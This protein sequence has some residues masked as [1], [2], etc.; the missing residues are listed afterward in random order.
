MKI[1]VIGSNGFIGK[2][3]V[4]RLRKHS[5]DE[6]FS[7]DREDIFENGKVICKKM[8]FEN[9]EFI[10]ENFKEIDLVYYLASL[11]I[12]ATS[13]NDPVIEIEKNLSPFLKFMEGLKDCG[14]KKI[15]YVSSAGT[16]YG[17]T[18]GKVKEE[19][20]KKPFSPY[21]IIK[22]TIENFLEHYKIKS[23]IHYDVFRISNAYGPG[24]DTSKGLGLINTFLEKII[25]GEEIKIF[26]DGTST[27]NYIFIDDIS[28]LMLLSKI[29]L[30]DGGIYNLS[31]D[32]TVDINKVVKTIRDV[33][34]EKFIPKYF[35]SRQSD[36][37][38]IDLDNSKILNQFPEF[39]FTTLQEGIKKTYQSLKK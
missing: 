18:H 39:A 33:V 3:L 34:S 26:G 15:V 25:S 21:G 1:A 31:S 35:P 19:E 32:S 9:K 12:P 10:K 8:N 16:V 7:F 23:G 36:N 13:W 27:R 20:N 28:E 24:Q 6:I 29:N 11:T 30:S 4:N 5:E 14:V 38:F 17:A 22:L 37:S 2:N